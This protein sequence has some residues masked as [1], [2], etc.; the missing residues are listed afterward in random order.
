MVVRSET[1]VVDGVVNVCGA[2]QKNNKG[3]R[4]DPVGHRRTFLLYVTRGRCGG[5][6]VFSIGE[7]GLEPF[8]C[9]ELNV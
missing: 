9:D 7:I 4:I 6:V 3:P 8:V 2:Q 1:A 5:H